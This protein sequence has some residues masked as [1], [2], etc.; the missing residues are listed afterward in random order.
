[1]SPQVPDVNPDVNNFSLIEDGA[2]ANQELRGAEDP[3]LAASSPQQQQQQQLLDQLKQEPKE[4]AGETR[5]RYIQLM[6][7]K[8][9]FFCV[10]FVFGRGRGDHE[11]PH[12]LRR[13]AAR[14]PLPRREQRRRREGGHPGAAGLQQAQIQVGKNRAIALVLASDARF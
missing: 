2:D 13:D 6:N 11:E 8:Y 7:P 9:I 12:R 1:M 10:F 4:A 3:V 5:K 14:A